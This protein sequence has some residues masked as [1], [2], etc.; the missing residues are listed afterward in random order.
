[1]KIFFIFAL[2]TFLNLGFAA[3]NESSGGV[4]EVTREH[5]AATTTDCCETCDKKAS[6][7]QV[8]SDRSISEN[9]QVTGSSGQLNPAGASKK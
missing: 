3:G 8:C 5:V 6:N 2:M 1:M 4:G 7:M 9:T